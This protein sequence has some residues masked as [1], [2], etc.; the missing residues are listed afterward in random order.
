MPL[1]E[2]DCSF[3]LRLCE[4]YNKLPA[5]KELHVNLTTTECLFAVHTFS[6]P[7]EL[8]LCKRRLENLCFVWK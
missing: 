3:R 2:Q 7:V 8:H 5:F 6:F 1:S 4:V